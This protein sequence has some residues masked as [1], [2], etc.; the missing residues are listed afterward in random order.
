MKKR[1]PRKNVRGILSD[2]RQI[3]LSL[4]YYLADSMV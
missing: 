4:K 2:P 1:T 3:S